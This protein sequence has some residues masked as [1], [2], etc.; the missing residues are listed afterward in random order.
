MATPLR[1]VPVRPPPGMMGAVAGPNTQLTYHHGHL[2]TSVKVFTIFWGHAW[3]APPQ[4]GLINQVNGF[5]DFVLTSSL[6]DLLS[7]YSVPGQQIG[8][9]TRVGSI[10]FG[11]S[12]PGNA[13]AGG[14]RL[15]TDSQIQQSLQGWIGNG[16]IPAADGNMLYFVYLPPGVVSELGGFSSCQE[17]CG[18]HGDVNGTIIYAVEP[19]LNC[20]GCMYGNGAFDSLTKV[21]SHELCEAITNPTNGGWWDDALANANQ[22]PEIGDICNTD[23]HQLGGFTVQSEW[24][25]QGSAC[26]MAP[27]AA[28]TVA[29]PDCLGRTLRQSKDRLGAVGLTATP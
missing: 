4:S 22:P 29:V 26:R 19:F 5:F 7:Q 3:T 12:E 20:A 15:I 6:I 24:S 10:T 1:I 8:H 18:Y 25:N 23:I 14:G 2:L 28:A 9:G 27:P 13:V 17:Y 11:N 21:S 16:S